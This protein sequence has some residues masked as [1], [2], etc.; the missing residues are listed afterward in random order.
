MLIILSAKGRTRRKA[1]NMTATIARISVENSYLSV[2]DSQLDI[3][4]KAIQPCIV[5]E[6]KYIDG[7]YVYLPQPDKQMQLVPTLRIETVISNRS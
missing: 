5:M 7:K 4:N 6:Q 1:K 3:I 2:T